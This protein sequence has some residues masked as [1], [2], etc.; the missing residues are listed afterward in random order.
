MAAVVEMVRK[1]G[2]FHLVGDKNGPRPFHADTVAAVT[3]R[4]CPP[5][6]TDGSL[7]LL[8]AERLPPSPP[9]SVGLLPSP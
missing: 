8:E 6:R 2:D 5:P 4:E 7:S 1:G 9:A 3:V